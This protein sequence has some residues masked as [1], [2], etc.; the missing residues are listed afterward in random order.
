MP[1]CDYECK[2]KSQIHYHHIIPKSMGGVD[3]TSNLIELCPNCHSRIYI[4]EMVYGGHAI[5]HDNSVILYGKLLSTEGYVIS[6]KLVN[7]DE[8]DY[9][10]L[11]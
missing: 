9:H 10:L 1:D 4:P 11:K 7:D 6:Y 3:S 5:K 8:I 2:D